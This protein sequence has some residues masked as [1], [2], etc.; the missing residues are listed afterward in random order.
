MAQADRIFK[1]HFSKHFTNHEANFPPTRPIELG[2][3]GIMENGYFKRYGNINEQFG[4]EF[5]IVP[6]NSP[7]YENF[8][9]DGSVGID[10]KAKGD[11][12]STGVPLLKAQIGFSFSSEKS[13]FF[14]AAGVKYLQ[15]NNLAVVGEKI[16]ELYRQG[17]WK[18]KYVVVSSILEAG[19]SLILISGSDQCNV[20]IEA[21]SD[22]IHEID[23][24]NTEIQF[25]IKTSS[26]VSYEILT[27]ECQLGFSLSKVYN[28]LFAGPDFRNALSRLEVSANLD[29]NKTADLNGLVFGNIAP[30]T[31]DI[32]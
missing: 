21:K 7:S 10:F 14:S 20:I 27:E 19:N 31:Y 25:G 24:T 28:P 6:D 1:Q 26:R 13:L 5:T 2:A 23:L 15:I 9:S 22:Q 30:G 16:I 3:Y 4:I 11:I 12:G 18:K 29:N 8:K 32:V 17:K